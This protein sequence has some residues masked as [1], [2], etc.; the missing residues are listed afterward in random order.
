MTVLKVWNGSAWVDVANPVTDHGGLTGLSDD[1]HSQYALADGTRGAYNLLHSSEVMGTSFPVSPS[2]ADLFFRSDL[3]EWFQYV[4]SQSAWFGQE[5]HS[6]FG[7]GGTGFTDNYLE[8]GG[9][10]NGTSARGFRPP[11][12]IAVTKLTANWTTAITSGAIEV[13]DDGVA[14]TTHTVS[15]SQ[16]G[17]T[18]VGSL[19]AIAA[20]S[21]VNVYLNGLSAGVGHPSASVFWRRKET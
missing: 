12:D 2:N 10:S 21:A 17:F 9:D 3:N 4:S 7:K 16:T 19:D 1:D 11:F 6:E 13:R 5:Q 18:K 14:V 20:A 8:F 15:V